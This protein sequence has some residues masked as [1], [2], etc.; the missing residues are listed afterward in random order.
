MERLWGSEK[1]GTAPR[2]LQRLSTRIQSIFSTADR[3]RGGCG[4]L[5]CY[6]HPPRRTDPAPLPRRRPGNPQPSLPELRTKPP[7]KKHTR[8]FRRRLRIAERMGKEALQF[9]P[10]NFVDTTVYQELEREGLLK[11]SAVE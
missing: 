4:V 2:S 6:Q 7:T 5:V 10:A 11:R 8:R 3:N 9:T 1:S